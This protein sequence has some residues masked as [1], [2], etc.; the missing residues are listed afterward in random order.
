MGNIYSMGAAL[1]AVNVCCNT[2][3][4]LGCLSSSG[5]VSSTTAKRL[6]VIIFF[7]YIITALIVGRTLHKSSLVK[8]H[9][10]IR[11]YNDCFEQKSYIEAC[12]NGQTIYRFA[13]GLMLVF[14]PSL[15]GSLI[16]SDLGLKF[17][18]GGFAL[19]VFLPGIWFMVSWFIPNSFFDVYAQI[20]IFFSGAFILV[21]LISLIDFA[22]VLNNQMTMKFADTGNKIWIVAL[23][24]GSLILSA[25][26]L[27]FPIIISVNYP[28]A[29]T[30]VTTSWISFGVGCLL[31]LFS[32]TDWCGHGSLFTASMVNAYTS[33][34][35]WQAAQTH[36]EIASDAP[37]PTTSITPVVL[38]ILISGV[39]LAWTAANI[40]G[41]PDLFHL[42]PEKVK[43]RTEMAAIAAEVERKEDEARKKKKAEEADEEEGTT[44]PLS[45]PRQAAG[46]DG[47][48]VAATKASLQWMYVAFVL[49]SGYACM[50]CTAWTS[51]SYPQYISKGQIFWGQMGVAWLAQLLFGWTLIAPLV[52]RNREFN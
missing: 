8:Q 41:S 25:I 35:S 43:E 42:D 36:P 27:T 6:N 22:Y 13:F 4:C 17:H 10:S 26:A 7:S 3:N 1:S 20:A 45:P 24:A 49:V 19:K 30:P 47:T 50:M 37:A 52:L 32:I 34:Y 31:T 28:A 15:L 33:F 2:L 14:L 9:E 18:R 38:S 29:S 40:S 11:I 44:T 51:N 16:G 21:Q 48:A 46:G 12:V 5:K 23:I 39:S